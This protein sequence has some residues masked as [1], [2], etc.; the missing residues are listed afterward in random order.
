MMVVTIINVVALFFFVAAT[1]DVDVDV[2][3]AVAVA[4]YDVFAFILSNIHLV[5][6][7]AFTVAMPLRPVQHSIG[8]NLNTIKR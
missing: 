3:V 7:A 2:A 4:A 5:R 8:Y 6:S 1:L